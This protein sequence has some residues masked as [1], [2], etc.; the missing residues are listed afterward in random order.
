MISR[1]INRYYHYNV[2]ARN[3][4]ATNFVQADANSTFEVEL[5]LKTVDQVIG[6]KK[7]SLMKVDCEGCEWAAIK[8]YDFIYQQFFAVPLILIFIF[9]FLTFEAQRD[10]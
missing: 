1:C 7:V 9:S 5:K 4:G 3:W 2:G 10:R 6:P 8:G